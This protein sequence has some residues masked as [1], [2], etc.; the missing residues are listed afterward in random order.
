MVS[1]VCSVEVVVNKGPEIPAVLLAV[2]LYSFIYLF[3][4][5]SLAMVFYGCNV[6]CSMN[7]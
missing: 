5:F 2:W 6:G 1:A 7:I 4:Y 3:I